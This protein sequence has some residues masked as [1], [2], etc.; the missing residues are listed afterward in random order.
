MTLGKPYDQK[1]DVFSFSIIMMELLTETTNPYGVAS[2]SHNIEVKVAMNP[3][4]RPQF[5]EDFDV[6]DEYKP[7]IS[8]M[9]RGWH[10]NPDERPTMNEI[11][12]YL[13]T[14]LTLKGSF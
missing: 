14:E 10:D 12:S 9:Q 11:L 8:L 6:R 4:F 13:E 2:N 7:Y 1:C 5:N 3:S